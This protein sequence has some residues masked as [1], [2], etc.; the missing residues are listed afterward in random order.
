MAIEA[1]VI[2]EVEVVS[3]SPFCIPMTGPRQG[4][5]ARSGMTTRSVVL[6]MATSKREQQRQM[7]PMGE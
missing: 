3:E 1:M 2:R 5:A 7:F 4:R 6:D